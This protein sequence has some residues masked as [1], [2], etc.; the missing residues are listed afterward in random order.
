MA[1]LRHRNGAVVEVPD[2][3]VAGLTARDFT[4]EETKKAPAKKATSK[5]SASAD[6]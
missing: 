2:E 5:K 1:R 3:K 4:A 6:D